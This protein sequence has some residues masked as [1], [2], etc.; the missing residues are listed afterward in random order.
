MEVIRIIILEYKVLLLFRQDDCFQTELER[1]KS[2]GIPV[3]PDQTVIPVG[4]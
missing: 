4:C 3:G 1:E 2:S